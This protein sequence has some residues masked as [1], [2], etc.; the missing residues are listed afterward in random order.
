MQHNE[1]VEYVIGDQLAM[2]SGMSAKA[3]F[4]GFG[5]YREG[6]IVGIVIADELYLKVDESNQ[7]VYE[8]MGSTPFS[9]EKKDGTRTTMSYWKI[10]AEVLEDREQLMLLV[11]QSYEINLKKE[12]MKSRAKKKT[13]N[14]SQARK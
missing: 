11:E 14:N 7:Q 5:I 4:G 3:M 13:K 1:F 10:P 2:I 9:Y 6:T 12:V 8:A